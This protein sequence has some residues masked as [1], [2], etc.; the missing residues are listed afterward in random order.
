MAKNIA[1][2][3]SDHNMEHAWRNI[4]V[5]H[6][7]LKM[8]NDL[9]LYIK[10]GKE[11]IAYMMKRMHRDDR[12]HFY[13][14]DMREEC[15]ENWDELIEKEID[16]LKEQQVGLVVSDICPWIFLAADELRIKSLLIGNY[17][18]VDLCG[19]KETLQEAYL[20]CYELASKILIYDLHQPSMMNYGVEYELISMINGAYNIEEIERIKYSAALPLVFTNLDG[21]YDVSG[22][23]YH[24]VVAGN[25][26]WKGDNVTCLPAD[27]PDLQNYIAASRFVLGK[28]S[29]SLIAQV[30]LANKK[31]ALA[32]DGNIPM[33]KNMIDLL[34][35]REQ[36]IQITEENMEDVGA[37]L[38]RLEEFSYSFEH[39]YHNDDYEIA[40]K[41]LFT[42][43]EKRRRSRS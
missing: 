42:Y 26:N 27:T 9:Q 2:Y 38:K 31:S 7:I 13:G 33:S 29:F 11:Q 36:C 34:T 10:S 3:I 41:I 20:E 14:M 21:N 35:K 24:F 17:T 25:E 43:P 18:W 5:L 12:L 23:P 30:V 32:V 37:V 28:G 1:F 16:F 39:E 8:E 15:P 22:L 4:P 19:E 6:T 40:K